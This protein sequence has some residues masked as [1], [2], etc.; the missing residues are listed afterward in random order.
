MRVIWGI[1]ISL[2]PKQW[3]KNLFVFAGLLFTLGDPHPPSD[4][5][6]VIAAFF[7]FCVLS[8]SVYLI[9]DL[10]DAERD[11]RHP[12]KRNRPIAS[13][14]ISPA[15]GWSAGVILGVA[16][17]ALSVLLDA[18]FGAAAAAYYALMTAYSLLLKEAMILDALAI[19][20]GFVLRAAAGALVIHVSIS[21]WLL[22][23]TTLLALFLALAKRRGEL[24]TL[25]GGATDYRAI[26]RDYTPEMLDQMIGVTASA[27]LMAYSLYTFAP[28]S[29]TAERHPMMMATI[30][31]V[32]FGL[33]RYLYLIHS[34]QVTDSP[35]TAL[36][37][38][39]QLLAS[40]ILWGA[41]VAAILLGF[42]PAPMSP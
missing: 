11:R 15:V 23:C 27:C 29:E 33:F 24:T 13:G 2:R 31:F 9:N 39:K 38:D 21:P 22:L 19:S 32:I 4:F 36:L 16:G 20:G 12:Y 28:F 40:V 8:G 34:K 18:K 30:P 25:E 37:S 6:R 5:A 1:M 42:P 10:L 35:E 26:L 17:L 3:T 7:L 14:L 41:A